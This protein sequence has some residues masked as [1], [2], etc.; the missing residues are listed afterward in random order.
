MTGVFWA[1]LA[2]VGFGVFQAFNRMARK[3]FSVYWATFI[4]LVISVLIMATASII[5]EDLSLLQ[6]AHWSSFFYLG[7]AGFIHFFLGWTLIN[8]SQN[9]VGAARTGALVGATPLFATVVA[10]L[11]FDEYLS[12]PVLA[13]VVTVV[14]GVYFV[15]VSGKN[16]TT[17]VSTSWRDSLYGLGVALCFSISAIF[18]RAGQENLPSPLL[19]VTVGMSVSA[20]AYG[21]LLLF[22]RDKLNLASVPN[23]LLL[24]QVAAG[25]MVGVSTWMRWI[26]LDLAPVGVV[27]ALVA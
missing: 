20:I 5:M 1:A 12:L 18:I 8:I 4:L 10:I 2:G 16:K 19:A 13:G 6:S 17:L 14:A 9:K 11:V 22:R 27:L 23:P 7:M 21:V 25:V 26:A 15:S 24:Y 3:G